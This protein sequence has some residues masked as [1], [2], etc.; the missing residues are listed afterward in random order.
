MPRKRKILVAFA[1]LAIAAAKD[2]PADVAARTAFE[3]VEAS[4]GIPVAADVEACAAAQKEAE[5]SGPRTDRDLF[6]ARGA[7]C[8]FLKALLSRDRAAIL[9]AAD[10][11]D[12]ARDGGKNSA[13]P[14]LRAAIDLA[15]LKASGETAPDASAGRDLR[16]MLPT[17]N[18]MNIWFVGTRTCNSLS[19]AANLWIGYLALRED[20]LNAA[21]EAFQRVEGT[22]WRPWLAGVMRLEAGQWR[23]ASYALSEA[24]NTWAAREKAR[25]V[26][27]AE[28]LGPQPDRGEIDARLGYTLFMS[29]DLQGAQARLD[30]AIA[31]RPADAFSRLLRARVEENTGLE[32]A[33]LADLEEAAKSAAPANA[34]FYRAVL[35]ERQR[36]F[37]ESAKEFAAVLA[38][39][40]EFSINAGYT[41]A[42]VIAW[43]AL[44]DAAGGACGA[45][46]GELDAAAANASPLF[47]RKD[48]EAASLE[49]KLRAASTLANLAALEPALRE[50]YAAPGAPEQPRQRIAAAYV[51]LGVAA[52][53]RKDMYS[54]AA[55][56]RRAL[57]WWP[58]DTKAR[59]N[60]ASIY[61]GD[62]KYDQ[63][64]QEYR[65]L[66][67]ADPFDH[68]AQYWLAESIL[69][70]HPDERRTAEACV[71]LAQSVQAPDAA[72]A[73]QFRAS[74]VNSACPKE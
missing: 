16:A 71:M 45:P 74:L 67:S 37:A 27:F 59:F 8:S 18:C 66:L 68:E 28:W 62:A 35:L 50:R 64:E 63:A 23:D 41:R 57:E 20:Q 44:A 51:R 38:S 73:A 70:A 34:P 17:V 1:C 24:S 65:L 13:G 15:K 33:G 69:A 7:Y 14:L 22:P 55:A 19:N 30:A 60:L 39:T 25:L 21:Q 54:A 42:D 32:Q 9:K 11:L 12:D 2:K 53:E 3:K 49:C 48:L 47:P 61:F 26:P 43:K 29:G 46:P 5:K 72:K 52:E 10:D 40:S 31:A 36:K 6:K 4:A 56:Y 58:R